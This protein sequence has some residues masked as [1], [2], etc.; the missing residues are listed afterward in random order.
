LEK[1]TVLKAQCGDID[2]MRVLYE[3]SFDCLYRYIRFKVSNDADAEDIVAEAFT[4]AFESIRQFKSQSTFKTYVYT[5]AKNLLVDFY[6]KN[7]QTTILTEE[8][9]DS[10][11]EEANSRVGSKVQKLLDHVKSVMTKLN[12]KENEVV[13]LRF[14]SGLNVDDVSKSLGLSESNVKVLTHRAIQKIKKYISNE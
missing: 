10:I 5:I 4:K 11:Q 9:A 8:F 2:A 13:T 12:S 3:S 1:E 7:S 14:I 6:K